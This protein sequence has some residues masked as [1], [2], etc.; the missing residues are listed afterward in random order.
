MVRSHGVIRQHGLAN[1]TGESKRQGLQHEVTPKSYAKV[2]GGMALHCSRVGHPVLHPKGHLPAL[3]RIK[4]TGPTPT[5]F[6][7][8]RTPHAHVRFPTHPHTAPSHGAHPMTHASS[9]VL[10]PSDTFP[11]RHNGPSEADIAEMLQLVGYASSMT[12]SATRWC[13]KPSACGTPLALAGLPGAKHPAVSRETLDV[14]A[15]YAAE[16]TVIKSFIGMGYYGTITPGV[17]LRNIMENP[18]W[19][20]Q[21]TP[22]QAEISQGRLEALLNFQTMVSDLTGLPLAGASLLDEGTAAAEAMAMCFSIQRRHCASGDVH[23]RRRLP[24][25]DHRRVVKTRQGLGMGVK[26][27]IADRRPSP[28]SAGRRGRPGAVPH[29]RRARGGLPAPC[30]EK[31]TPPVLV[32]VATDLLALAVLKPPPNGAPTAPWATRSASACRWASAARTPRSSQQ[33]Q[34]VRKM[35][36]RIIGVS[37]DAQW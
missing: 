32:V 26:V 22:Y 9:S 24:P 35:P 13:P 6:A 3:E 34:Y 33:E 27:V 21:Y 37:K 29:H 23:R 28:R 25:A 1:N 20:T 4:L 31:C 5:I 12:P 15:G 2:P 17:I 11:H 10:N 7:P 14:L 8:R 36:G 16:N 30:G 18:G 19:Y